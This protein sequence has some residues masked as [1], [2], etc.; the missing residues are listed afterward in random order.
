MI[1]E[2]Q[3]ECF[4]GGEDIGGGRSNPYYVSSK[5]KFVYVPNEGVGEYSS[6]DVT[7]L[8][9]GRPFDQL[10]VRAQSD[11]AV[12]ITSTSSTRGRVEVGRASGGASSGIRTIELY[13]DS[14]A[15]GN[16]RTEQ[17][18]I[19]LAVEP[20]GLDA[21]LFKLMVEE[22]GGWLSSSLIGGTYHGVLYGEEERNPETAS[23]SLSF[24]NGKVERLESLFHTIKEDPKFRAEK[25]YVKSTGYPKRRDKKS[26]RLE[27]TDFSHDRYTYNVCRSIDCYE[28]RLILEAVKY[29]E[30]YADEISRFANSTQKDLETSKVHMEKFHDS[31]EEEEEDEDY[32]DLILKLDE[33]ETKKSNIKEIKS[34]VRRIKHSDLM[35]KCSSE[36]ISSLKF[37]TSITEDRRY[38]GVMEVLLSMRENRTFRLTSEIN[39]FLETD[40]SFGTKKTRDIFE[41][42]TLYAVV[43]CLTEI[44]YSVKGKGIEE[45]IASEPHMEPYLVPGSCVTLESKNMRPKYLNVYYEETFH[46]S[47]GNEKAKPDV[48]I[49][50]INEHIPERELRKLPIDAKYIDKYKEIDKYEK[51]DEKDYTSVLL[52][53]DVENIKDSYQPPKFADEDEGIY[54]SEGCVYLY[55]G[56]E[57]HGHIAPSIENIEQGS[58]M[59]IILP[60][61]PGHTT[62][63]K[64]R[65]ENILNIRF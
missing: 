58:K 64:R 39:E 15:G 20:Q 60:V 37:P 26:R 41:Y 9:Y 62:F 45:N 51:D 48:L 54:G 25:K 6:D 61:S 12:Q 36:G 1:E 16:Q 14:K 42:W 30:R 40:Y 46:Y 35:R 22:V 31:K 3:I 53:K 55:P 7:L 24:L 27:R 23:L 52:K 29:A 57:S 49:K 5:N 38:R 47:N 19:L 59:E 13:C 50:E 18:T 10:E 21:E 34:K 63:L 65:L 44:G 17:L 4:A 2:I 43:R 56:T 32:Q 8:F 11:S 28:N 33:I